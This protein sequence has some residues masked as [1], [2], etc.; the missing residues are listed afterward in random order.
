MR[1]C[2]KVADR[3]VAGVR[4]IERMHPMFETTRQ[5]RSL[6]MPA[7]GT[8]HILIVL[9]SFTVLM[10]FASMLMAWG[11]LI[12]RLVTRQPILPA[13]PMVARSEPP[14]GIGSSC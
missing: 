6:A 9:L 2:D 1:S 11:W 4:S 3:A 5:D 7:F 8:A 12:W 10:I 13:E 14:W